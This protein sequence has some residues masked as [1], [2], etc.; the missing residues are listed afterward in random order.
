MRKKTAKIKTFVDV[1]K[2]IRNDWGEVNPV[3]K[4]IPNKKKSRKR[5]YAEVMQNED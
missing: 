3:T 1:I 4:I 2:W 5:K